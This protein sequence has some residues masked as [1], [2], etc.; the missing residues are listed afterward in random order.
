MGMARLTKLRAKQTRAGD[1][2]TA[3]DSNLATDGEVEARVRKHSSIFHGVRDD[4][5]VFSFD[6]SGN[7]SNI[8]AYIK[9]GSD[10]LKDTDFSFDASGNLVTI[11]SEVFDME[12]NS[13]AKKQKDFYY[14]ENNNINKI[15][16][17]I[18]EE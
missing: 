12:L 13:Y 16:N 1:N 15:I 7:L 10:V 17:I 8:T 14:D 2:Y 9:D 11:I 3:D 5:T 18:I 6:D 4:D